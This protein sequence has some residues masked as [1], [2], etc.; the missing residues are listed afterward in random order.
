MNSQTRLIIDPAASGAWNMSV[1]QAL[2]ETVE[3]SGQMTLRIY[4]WEPATIS[5]GYFQAYD[6]RQQHEA[7]S[8]CPVVRRKTGGGAIVHDQEITYSL[9][10]PS[11]ERWSSKNSE[12]Y[13]LVH[14]SLIELFAGYGVETHLFGQ[15]ADESTRADKDRFLCFQRRAEGDLILDRSKVGGSAQRRLKKSLL[16][17]GS[18]LLKR[19][20]SAPELAGVEDLSGVTLAPSEFVSAWTKRLSDTLETRLVEAVLSPQEQEKAEKYQQTVF[21]NDE[22]NR[23]R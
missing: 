23:N 11:S 1:D 22:W 2:L 3:Q 14:N 13:D 6:D 17:H 10:V 21:Q 5:L 18:I 12:L 20:A 9:C 16:Q 19:S 7:S 4:Q 8:N 15:R